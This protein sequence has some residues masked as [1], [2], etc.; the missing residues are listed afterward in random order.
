MI[1]DVVKGTNDVVKSN[2]ELIRNQQETQNKM[3]E[4]CKNTAN[5][6]AGLGSTITNNVYNHTGNNTFNLQLFLNEDCKDAMNMSD[7]VKSIKVNMEDLENVGRVGYVEGISSIF[8][9]NL[10][11]TDIH[12]RPIHC[13]DRKRE[14]LYVK[15]ANRWERDD[16]NSQK[17]KHAVRVVEQKNI[18][19]INEW[20]KQHPDC[21]K[22]DTC[23]NKLYM[24]MSGNA[25]DGEDE[26]IQK[27]LKKVAQNVIIH[28]DDYAIQ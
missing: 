21:D 5:N 8:I 12:K 28:K 14:V 25:L 2:N 13:S 18:G 9:D 4:I 6:A 7:F 17:L 26:N 11:N 3:I 20:A 16:V 22:S 19:M 10:K 15:D 27:V 24:K 1:V 23:A